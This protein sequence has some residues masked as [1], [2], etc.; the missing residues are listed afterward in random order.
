MSC[1]GSQEGLSHTYQWVSGRVTLWT[2][3]QSIKLTH[4]GKQP[5][6]PRAKLESPVNLMEL[7][8]IPRENPRRLGENI[9]QFDCANHCTTVLPTSHD[10]D[11]NVNSEFMDLNVWFL[12]GHSWV[13]RL[14]KVLEI[15]CFLSDLVVRWVPGK[16]THASSQ[17]STD[18]YNISIHQNSWKSN[19][20]NILKMDLTLSK[21][22]E[23]PSNIKCFSFRKTKVI[24]Y[25]L[26]DSP[27]EEMQ[28]CSWA[29]IN[30]PYYSVTNDVEAIWRGFKEYSKQMLC[31]CFSS[32]KDNFFMY[33]CISW[34]TWMDKSTSFP[35]IFCF[36]EAK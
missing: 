34:M 17:H 30:P 8:R 25:C 32:K 33:L 4:R 6:T 28:T 10:I 14:K 2:G 15:V 1:T 18:S 7:P 21:A 23:G 20:F 27:W 3:H 24:C 19:L 11:G 36:L 12:W 26:F 5:I 16:S 13:T 31:N 9:G 29:A 35:S 22:T